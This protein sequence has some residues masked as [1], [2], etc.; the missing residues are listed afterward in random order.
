MGDTVNIIYDKDLYTR[1]SALG[2][3]STDAMTIYLIPAGFC[4]W[5]W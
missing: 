2:K 1:E 3:C 5:F 4:N